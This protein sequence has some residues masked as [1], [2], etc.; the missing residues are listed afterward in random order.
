MA[1]RIIILVPLLIL[2]HAPLTHA[3]IATGRSVPGPLGTSAS[4]TSGVLV[5]VAAGS[6][7]FDVEFSEP[8]GNE[9]LEPRETGRMRVAISNPGSATVKGVFVKLNPLQEVKGVSYSDSIHVGDIPPNS[10]QYGVF[11]FKAADQLDPQIVTFGVEV[12]G[13]RGLL[14]DP[15]LLTF[16]TR[17]R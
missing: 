13:G 15:K 2:L 9:Y 3:Q 4:D 7:S 5:P 6:V 12:R 1:M 14:A 8:S 17:Q 10:S 11:Y 16:L